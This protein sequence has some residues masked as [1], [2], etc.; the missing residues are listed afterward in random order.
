M[1]LYRIGF[2]MLEMREVVIAL[3]KLWYCVFAQLRTSGPIAI[4][5]ESS[6]NIFVQHLFRKPS[7]LSF[8]AF[9]ET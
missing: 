6:K 9:S 3:R 7:E 1:Y 8:K 5:L 2:G 4:L